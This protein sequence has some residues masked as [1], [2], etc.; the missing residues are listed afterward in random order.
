MEGAISVKSLGTGKG[1]TFAF[2]VPYQD[3]EN[4]DALKEDLVPFHRST[5]NSRNILLVEDNAVNQLVIK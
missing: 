4:N 5:S 2:W 1:S 3:L